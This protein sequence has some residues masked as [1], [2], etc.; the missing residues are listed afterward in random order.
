MRVAVLGSTGSIGRQ[1]L[2]VLAGLEDGFEV[3]ALAAASRGA[4][5]ADQAAA[6]RPRIV[7]VADRTVRAGLIVPAGTE[8]DDSEDGLL[9]LATLEDV[10]M[11]VVGTTGIVSLGPVLAALGAGK[12][13]AT[14][15]KETLVAG[16][17]L[18]MAIASARA[19]EVA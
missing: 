3:V 6:A 17:H 19:A 5:L 18:V 4:E 15:N 9:R 14:A 13:V 1:A 10:D 8:V 2:E 16:G 11:V 12:I 7:A